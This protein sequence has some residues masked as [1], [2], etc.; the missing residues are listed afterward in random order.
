VSRQRTRSDAEGVFRTKFLIASPQ[1]GDRHFTRTVVLL[2]DH[3]EQGAMGLVINRATELPLERVLND[4]EVEHPRPI[5][6]SVLWGGPVQPGTGF[7]IY[8]AQDDEPAQER[9]V[10]RVSDS[11]RIT[12]SRERLDEYAKGE[13]TGPFYLCLGYSG[14]GP[15]QLEQEI[16]Q[17]SWI[18]TDVEE[19]LIFH[20]RIED[21]WERAI[22]SLGID[23]SMIWMT[24]VNE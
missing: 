15:G 8:R 24:P 2:C 17:G 20:T 13:R 6:G 10:L 11:L 22:A 5:D 3:S 9:G 4:L 14:W 23:I 7:L 21:R 18:V 1:M 16:S 19:D 12:G